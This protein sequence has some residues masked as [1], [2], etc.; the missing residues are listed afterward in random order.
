MTENE[1]L[2]ELLEEARGAVKRSMGA[3]T[4]AGY[5]DH[6]TDEKALL[7]RIDAALAEPAT[8]N[9]LRCWALGELRAIDQRKN[10]EAHKELRAAYAELHTARAEGER[11]R[12]ALICPCSEYDPP[13]QRCVRCDNEVTP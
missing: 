8:H 4:W 3:W 6:T 2:R 13:T 1:K 11:L 5:E 10:D 7:E 12:A 9:C